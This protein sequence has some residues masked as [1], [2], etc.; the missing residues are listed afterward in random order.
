M[1]VPASVSI[2][3][4]LEVCVS[5]ALVLFDERE[6]QYFETGLVH[7][8]H[9]CISVA[10]FNDS[11]YYD[12]CSYHMSIFQTVLSTGSFLCHTT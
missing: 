3:L 8:I 7:N 4:R 2:L 10:C 5:C 12:L 11:S 9:I 1:F 6:W